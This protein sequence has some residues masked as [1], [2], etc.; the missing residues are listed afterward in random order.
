MIQGL[1]KDGCRTLRTTI[2]LFNKSKLPYSSTN[3]LFIAKVARVKM[4]KKID[5]DTVEKSIPQVNKSKLNKTSST[6]HK[7]VLFKDAVAP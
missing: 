3:Y 7:K 6:L 2:N 5:K 1:F 4:R